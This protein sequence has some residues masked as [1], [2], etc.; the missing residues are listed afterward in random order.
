VLEDQDRE[1]VDGGPERGS[2]LEDVDA[3]LLALDHPG[4]ATDLALHPRQA[5]DEAGLVLRVAVAEV[6]G[7]RRRAATGRAGWHEADLRTVTGPSY[8]TPWGYCIATAPEPR[9][10][11]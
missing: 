4:D 10:A 2:L 6:G 3:V 11:G 8:D 7:W 5:T 1:R 9:G